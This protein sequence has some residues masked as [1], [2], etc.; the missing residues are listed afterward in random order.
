M[1]ALKTLSIITEESPAWS[2]IFLSFCLTQLNTWLFKQFQIES[3]TACR[4]DV[5]RLRINHQAITPV[6]DFAP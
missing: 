1:L 6:V 4:T 2:D 5:C 3:V